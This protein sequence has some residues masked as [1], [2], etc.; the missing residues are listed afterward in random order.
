MSWLTGRDEKESD[1]YANYDKVES[2][3]SNIKNISSNQVESARDAVHAAVNDLNNVNGLAQFVGSV[4]AGAF[5]GVFESIA[6]AIV[7]V[8][9]QVQN[10]ANDIKTYE[11]S[12]WYE[13]LG[14]TFAMAGAKFGEGILS[15]AEDLGDGV[16][17]V[18]GWIAPKDSG[19]EQACKNFV[20]KEWSHDAFNFYYNSEFAKKSTF[21]EDSAAAAGFKI[22]GAT[23]GYLYLGGAISGFAGE[24]K[25]AN[26]ATK[27]IKTFGSSTTK[28]NTATAALSGMGSGTE[29]GLR[30]GKSFD[31][32]AWGGAKQGV[33]Q[34]GIAYGMGKLGERSAKK[35]T[36]D[37]F[38]GSGSD[39]T[40]FMSKEAAKNEI[41]QMSSL[42]S[43][44]KDQFKKGIDEM[45]GDT[46][47]RRRIVDELMSGKNSKLNYYQGYNDAITKAGQDFGKSAYGLGSSAKAYAAAGK[48]YA[49]ANKGYK[50][51][52]KGLEDGQ[53]V[54]QEIALNRDLAAAGKETAKQ[55]LKTSAKDIL[56]NN[57]VS[58]TASGVKGVASSAKTSLTN[59]KNTVVNGVKDPKGTLSSI[60]EGAKNIPT[61]VKN[62]VKNIPSGIKSAASAG[63]NA[64]TTSPSAPGV[65]GATANAAGREIVNSK[66][67]AA[68][69]FRKT[70]IDKSTGEA[71][72]INSDVDYTPGKK[73][74]IGSDTPQPSGNTNNGGGGGSTGGYSGG[75]SSSGGGYSGGGGGYSGGGGTTTIS[76]SPISSGNEQFRHNTENDNKSKNDN[77][78]KKPT[79]TPSGTD[80]KPTTTTP[81]NPTN[82][83][84]PTT[85]TKPDGNNNTTT[86]VT[87]PS[88]PG[89]N[90][91]QHTGGGYSGSGGYRG[92]T[93]VR[94][95][96][97]GGNSGV[98]AD[99]GTKTNPIEDVT[100]D[101]TT[102][103]DDVIKG[104]KY[105]KIPT[106]SKPISTTSTS[107]SGGS[108][109]IP[110]VAGLSAA[111][112][113]GIGAKV[114]MDRKKNNENGEYDE[115]DTEE[116]A[117]ED[118]I[119][120]DYDDS[121]DTETYLDEDDDYGYQAEEQTERYDARNNEELADLQ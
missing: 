98:V 27:A 55:N 85:P 8:G 52:S 37:D 26:A 95:S 87:K 105:T 93:G 36:M 110:V 58:Q 43:K 19:F 99:A 68:E 100:S 40:K 25:G 94:S 23:T 66:G 32:A 114:Y 51:A 49:T 24:M 89:T 60:K 16:V 117:G 69:Q 84:N 92:D 88:N 29:S 38:K 61:N 102:S 80:K 35:Q 115:I 56:K 18:A 71:V 1:V 50:K 119:N 6:S 101:T 111:A 31:E 109:V 82:P 59:G 45:A 53:I 91:T 22:A 65:I 90:T 97:V 112:A 30:Q 67:N 72:K 118:T 57:P 10:K 75:G 4:D 116:W 104:S 41:D 13:K 54:D 106:S 113:A 96:T 108:T 86:V 62:G 77:D 11:E 12:A 70:A 34:G 15:V 81:T 121:S 3:V 120:L 79:E 103:I 73:P 76:A 9:E 2:V 5:D 33:I 48:E 17:S 46:V 20:E 28:V 64:I 14:S 21:T 7:Q 83:T 47:T 39:Q 107:G 74:I 42:T 44:G 78:N 63:K